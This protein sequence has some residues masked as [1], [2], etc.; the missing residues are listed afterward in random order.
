MK[1]KKLNRGYVISKNSEKNI[2]K[3]GKRI[4]IIPLWKLLLGKAHIARI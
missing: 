2:D 3:K 4:T 1:E